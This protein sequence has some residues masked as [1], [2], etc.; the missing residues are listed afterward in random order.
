LVLLVALGCLVA[1]TGHAAEAAGAARSE[2]AAC[3]DAARLLADLR[4]EVGRLSAWNDSLD[5]LVAGTLA[6]DVTLEEL[7][8]VDAEGHSSAESVTRLQASQTWP[9]EVGCAALAQDYADAR[10]D[11][12]WLRNSI[13]RKRQAFWSDT[14]AEHQAVLR[15]I[16]LSRQRLTRSFETVQALLGD[17]SVPGG[18]EF[19]TRLRQD[20]EG[21]REFRLMLFRQLTGP[22]AQE[23]GARAR[24]LIEVWRAA[25]DRPPSVH[26]P[27]AVLLEQWP[28][29]LRTELRRFAVLYEDDLA[30]LRRQS[31]AV[32]AAY[33]TRSDLDFAERSIADAG[34]RLPLLALELRAIGN[35]ILSSGMASGSGWRALAAGGAEG[36]R[37]WLRLFEYLL[38]LTALPVLALVARGLGRS[39]LS[40]QE[41]IA[42]LGKSSRGVAQASRLTAALPPLLPWVVGWFGLDVLAGLYARQELDLLLA[43][44]PLVRLYIVFNV[45]SIAGTW[46]V[47]TVA[48]HG[49]VYLS[50]EA[51]RETEVAS[52]WAASIV[53][54]PWLLAEF[55][56]LAIG[57][58]LLH[59][60]VASLALL[61]LF[62]AVSFL[63][64][65][66]RADVLTAAKALLPA[67]ADRWIDLL[68][69][70]WR[71]PLLAP[72]A[73][74]PFLVWNLAHG[75]HRLALGVDS[76]RKLAARSFMLRAQVVERAAET[77]GE[78]G[79]AEDY[80]CWFL[81]TGAGAAPP[82][83]DV[84]LLRRLR[85]RMD[86]WLG[87]RTEENTLLLVGQ[88]GTGKTRALERLRQRL[89]E[90]QPDLAVRYLAVPPK[91]ISGPAVLGLVGDLLGVDLSAGPAALVK[92]DAERAPTLI[93]LDDAHNFFLR[94]VGG[95][96][97]WQTLLGL[98]NARVANVFW[99]IAI[100]DQS[101]AY[102]ANVFARDYQFR[103]IVWTKP[104]TQSEIRSLIL[105]RNQ[106]SRYRIRYDDVLLATRGPEAGSVRNAEQRYFGLLWDACDGNPMLALRLWLSS[107]HTERQTAVVGLPEEPSATAIDRLAADF[108]F[109]YAAIVIHVTMSSD[110]LVEVTALN[111]GLVR[112]A[113]KTGFDMGFVER[114]GDGRYRIVP[115]WYPAVVGLLKRKNM[116]HE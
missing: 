27:D 105:S 109:V 3:R 108:Q 49:G 33:W 51:T 24:G 63:L 116:L 75:L 8:G 19:S 74:P 103:N 78:A 110:E 36:R 45:V 66:R 18:Q 77:E 112:A 52:R 89:A 4:A 31:N 102:L 12:V 10:A 21:L 41:R 73:V 61:A 97:G 26:A 87:D 90:E 96:E 95:L 69:G 107:V 71:F 98:T 13:E 46:L 20:L 85:E 54:L 28:V 57:D 44:I 100:N 14:G 99:L 35:R 34:G 64:M 40:V 65:Q 111:G 9:R 5:A 29:E 101:W 84:G 70:S 6:S 56:G 114:S 94:R 25:V 42:R 15:E 91:T 7:F 55:V 82:F 88:R 48:E 104:W 115:I 2:R 16:W 68:L 23:W 60:L 62:V 113:L 50:G 1:T 53:M 32:R 76:Y 93:V 22:P 30:L 81:D 92:G 67:A 43:L 47:L 38:W 79:I 17:D 86:P 59:D 106:L 72:L 39:A 58:S 80:G 11:L 83:L 37:A